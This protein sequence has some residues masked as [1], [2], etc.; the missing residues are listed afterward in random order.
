[1]LLLWDGEKRLNGGDAGA[2]RLALSHRRDH[3]RRVFSCSTGEHLDAAEGVRVS[4]LRGSVTIRPPPQLLWGCEE[5]RAS[6][7]KSPP[8]MSPSQSQ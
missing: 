3:G 5:R 7:D 8:Q 1:M 4:P 6:F 2:A